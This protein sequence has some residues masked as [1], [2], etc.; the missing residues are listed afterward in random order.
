MKDFIYFIILLLIAAAIGYGFDALFSI[1]PKNSA[2][3]FVESYSIGIR[4]L[5]IHA[6]VCG[7]IGLVISFVLIKPFL[8]R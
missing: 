2:S 1:L 6:S 8:N 5:G 7:I 4:P 3:F